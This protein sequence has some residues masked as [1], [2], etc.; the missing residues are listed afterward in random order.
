M[1]TYVVISDTYIHSFQSHGLHGVYLSKD[2]ARTTAMDTVIST[3]AKHNI[4]INPCDVHVDDDTMDFSYG[5]NNI[6]IYV[7]CIKQE[8]Q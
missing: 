8:V 1:T 7:S 4:N 6:S 2:S 3:M 5:C